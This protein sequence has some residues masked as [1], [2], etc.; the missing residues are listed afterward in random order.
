MRYGQPGAEVGSVGDEV[1]P[2]LCRKFAFLCSHVIAGCRLA[3]GGTMDAFS[4]ALN[5]VHVTAAIFVDAEFTA[6]W[7]FVSPP[8]EQLAPIVAPGVE[9]VVMYHLIASGEATLRVEGSPDLRVSAGDIVIVPHGDL[10]TVFNGNPTA[11]TSSAEAIG[12]YWSGQVETAYF[13]GGGAATKIVCGFFGCERHAAK[14]F[15]A[16]LP[17]LMKVSLRDDAAGAWIEGSILHLCKE[18]A[19][20]RPGGTVLLS[21]MAE[22]LFIESL[23]RHMEQLPPEQTGWLAGARDVVVGSALA[24]MHRR[25]SHPWTLAELAAEAGTSRSVLVERFQRFLDEPPLTYLARWR[26][27]LAARRLQTTRN[28]VLQVAAEV[29]YESEA[30]FNR[31][32][33]REF[34]LPPAQYRSR[35]S[36]NG[37]EVRYERETRAGA[38]SRQ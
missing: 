20:K 32:F 28:T 31:A 26:M 15:L 7:G 27:Q 33:K 9:R 23:R 34:Q 22:A 24:L 29:G 5:S 8:A 13:G 16:G 37:A 30:A 6:P 18:A 17:P 36:E 25:P 11:L 19:A 4:A 14:L 1:L 12:K 10:H 3:E 38:N 35:L 21:K 2:R